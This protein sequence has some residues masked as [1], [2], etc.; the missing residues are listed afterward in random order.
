MTDNRIIGVLGGS[1]NPIH[2]GHMEI[3]VKTHEQFHIPEILLMPTANNYYKD[4]SDLLDGETRLKMVELA[5]SDFNKDIDEPY[6]FSS[7]LDIDRG[8]TTYTADTIKD[9][10]AVYDTIYFII[11]SDSLMYI[12]TWKNIRSILQNATVLYAK[13]NTDDQKEIEEQIIKLNNIYQ[14]D[15]R[16]IL[17]EDQPFSSSMI[18]Q[19]IKHNG[20]IRPYVSDSVYRYIKNNRLYQ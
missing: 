15:I 11:G 17:I 19:I 3:A 14:A 4:N 8:G 7:S 1:F 5:I 2:K 20:D 10:S 16:P 9:L 13:R 6:I 12:H 18:R